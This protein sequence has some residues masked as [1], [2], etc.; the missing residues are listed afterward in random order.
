MVQ[1]G[2]KFQMR[3]P[4]CG[5]SRTNP[6][7][8]RGGLVFDRNECAFY[9]HCFNCET[10]YPFKEFLRRIDEGLYREYLRRIFKD[11]DK[12]PNIKLK[13]DAGRV[14]ETGQRFITRCSELPR[15]HPAL[16]YLSSRLVPEDSFGDVFFTESYQDL[17][18]SVF[19]GKYKWL[20]LKSGIV[21]KLEDKSG[22]FSGYQCRTINPFEKQF[23]F[24]KVSGS[25]ETF[26]RKGLTPDVVLEGPL[27]ALFFKNSV[28]ACN[29]NLLKWDSGDPIYFYDQEPYNKYIFNQVKRAARLGKTVCILP[30]KYIGM[31]IAD[32]V[33]KE[34]FSQK[35]LLE[36]IRDFSCSGLKAKLRLSEWA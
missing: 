22:L 8:K 32:I 16:K 3:C 4:F 12:S 2:E 36:F 14:F 17:A 33:A 30:S 24:Q 31:D 23:R 6:R 26:F 27:D 7:K 11:R 18:N 35:E 19:P 9:F 1:T 5:D 10:S 29:S 21:W 20:R 15:G 34:W 28:A 13:E 25:R